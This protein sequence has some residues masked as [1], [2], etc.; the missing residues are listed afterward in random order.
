[1]C[2]IAVVAANSST[3]WA[4]RWKSL[5]HCVTRY[6][7]GDVFLQDHIDSYMWTFEMLLGWQSY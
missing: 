2:H 4:I 6:Y 3:N 1:M 7:I 5:P